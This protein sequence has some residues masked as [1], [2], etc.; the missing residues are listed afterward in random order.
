MSDIIQLL[1]DSVANQIAAGEVVQRPASAVKELMENALDAGSTHIQLIVKDAGKTLI[2]VIDNGCGMSETDA[3]LSFERHATSKIR[4]AEDLFS[5]RTMGFRGEALA[6]IA[7]IAQVEL[8]TRQPDKELGVCIEIEGSEVKNQEACSASAGTSISVKNLFYNIPARRNFLKTDTV[9]LR[10][11]IDEFQRVAI[12]NPHIAFTFHSNNTEVFHLEAGSL[13]Q[14]LMGIFGA[15]YNSRLV[16]VEEETGVV[17]IKGFI[18]KPEF[19]KKTRGEQFFFLNKRFIK[20]P[21]LHHAVQSAFEQLLPADS[22]ASYFLLLDVDPKTIDINIHPTKTEVKFEDEKLIYAFLR[23]AVKKSLGQFNIAPSLDFDQEAHLYNMPLKPSDGIYKQPTIKVDP[24]FNPF[25]NDK[26][27]GAYTPPP[28]TEREKSNKDNWERMYQHNPYIKIEPTEKV[29]Q[30]TIHTN[31]DKEQEGNKKTVYQLHNS[32]ILSHIKTGFI[33]IDQQGA[34]ERILYERIMEAFEKNKS[35]T[36]QELFPKTVEFNLSDFELVKELHSEI[37]LMGFDIQEFGKNTYVIHGIP[38]DM[39][40]HDPSILLE[41]LLENYK[42]N[43][44]ELRS[45]KRE[46]LAR[47]MAKNMAIKS[48][49]SL[50]Q[51]E[52]SNLIDE[53]FA[54]QMPYSTPAGK[55]TI[56]TFSMDDLD[57]RFKK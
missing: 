45:N 22:F 42:Q 25:K 13:K 20:N 11:I 30:Q 12:P 24:N 9:E 46:N 19:A 57:K 44:Q 56:T 21:Y 10:H 39:V 54:C 27:T 50:N 49:K 29:K 37:Q 26:E 2:Q 23:S 32:Y 53:L 41:G 16:P 17:K 7:A 34:H 36:Q 14:R 18:I 55:P 6:S 48:G 33:V 8:K 47:S 43:L 35:S 31:W 3:R 51:E 40:G 5:I 52:M 15:S 28:L 38:A 4:K 1:P